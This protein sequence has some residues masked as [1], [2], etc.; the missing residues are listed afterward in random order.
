V[1]RTLARYAEEWLFLTRARP[2]IP[3]GATLSVRAEEL[4]REISLFMLSVG[5]YPDARP[6]PGRYFDVADRL[7]QR[8]TEFVLSFH[9]VPPGEEGLQRIA[10]FDD[11]CVFR[12]GAAR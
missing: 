3:D 10:V 1:D 8:R 11:G 9:C 2:L 12:R 7:R 5:L 6:L 4:P